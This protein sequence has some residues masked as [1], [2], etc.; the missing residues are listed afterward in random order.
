MHCF[1]LVFSSETPVSLRL[2]SERNGNLFIIIIIII[3]VVVVVVITT[4][5]LH[6]S[7]DGSVRIGSSLIS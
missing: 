5:L 6:W 4:A 1:M 2:S 3:I 7:A